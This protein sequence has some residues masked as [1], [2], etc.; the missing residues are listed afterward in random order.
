MGYWPSSSSL[1]DWNSKRE[2]VAGD[3]RN[4]KPA[5]VSV[6]DAVGGMIVPAVAY[7]LIAR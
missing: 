1:P 2:L 5:V 6:A 7:L 3:L 4:P